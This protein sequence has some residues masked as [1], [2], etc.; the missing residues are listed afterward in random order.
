MKI[1]SS[2]SIGAISA[3]LAKAQSE[4]AKAV[5]D[6]TNPHFKSKYA[7]LSSCLDATMP[8]LNKHGIALTQLPGNT[9]GLVSLTTLL[10]HS[11]GEYI[12]CEA[13]MAPQKPGPHAHGS[14]LT[15]L[16]RYC[17]AAITGLAQADDDGNAGQGRKPVDTTGAE[18]TL[19]Q[20]AEGGLNALKTAWE[21]IKL[22]EREAIANGKAE[23]WEKLKSRAADV[24]AA[25]EAA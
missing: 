1:F 5:T 14:A 4:M 10:A 21:G 17:L 11:S 8:A 16:R 7:D 15:Y 20:A 18:A 12:G 9:D 22:A 23:W 24:D 6:S 25:K 2:D 3:A 19:S 13:S